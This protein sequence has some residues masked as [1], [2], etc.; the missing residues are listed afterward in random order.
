MR[1]LSVFLVAFLLAGGATDSL[2]KPK[3]LNTARARAAAHSPTQAEPALLALPLPSASGK[4]IPA[5]AGQRKF[6]VP[7]GFARVER[8][9]RRQLGG[10]DKVSLTVEVSASGR[11]LT[12]TSRRDTDTWSKAVARQGAV[13]TTIEVTPIVRLKVVDIEGRPA[14][15]LVHFVMPPSPEVARQA[16]SIDHLETGDHEAPLTS[17]R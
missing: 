10:A 17:P 12:L 2:A 6:R 7:L 13:D 1:A 16:N 4:P 8:F 15:P 3:P 5:T 9:Y 11:T 14:E